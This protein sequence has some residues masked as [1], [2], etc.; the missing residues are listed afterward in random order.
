VNDMRPDGE[1]LRDSDGHA[2]TPLDLAALV[3]DERFLQVGL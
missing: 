1:R 2:W 3:R